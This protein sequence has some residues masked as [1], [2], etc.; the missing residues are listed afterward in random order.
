MRVQDHACVA[1]IAGKENEAGDDA[2]GANT[3]CDTV[4]CGANHHV[5]GHQCVACPKR[6]RRR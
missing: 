6:A 2:S 3:Q 1:C 5:Q 4:V